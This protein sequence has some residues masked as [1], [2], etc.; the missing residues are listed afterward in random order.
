MLSHRLYGDGNLSKK[1]TVRWPF[2]RKIDH[3]VERGSLCGLSFCV[4]FSRLKC[5][6]RLSVI[7]KSD[8]FY[9]LQR[10]CSWILHQLQER[11]FIRLIKA[12]CGRLTALRYTRTEIPAVMASV[13]QNACQTPVGPSRRQSTQAMGIMAMM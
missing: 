1:A 3:Y 8:F 4:A 10:S 7:V 6:N 13:I 11:C 9:K 2:S 5:K 12:Y